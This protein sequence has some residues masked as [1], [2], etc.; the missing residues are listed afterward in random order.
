VFAG[1]KACHDGQEEAPGKWSA[2]A[3]PVFGF[4][5]MA[6]A[7]YRMEGPRCGPVIGTSGDE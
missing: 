6:G 7:G 1:M 3:G 2:Q 4:T 5:S